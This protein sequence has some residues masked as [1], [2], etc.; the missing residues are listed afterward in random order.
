[1]RRLGDIGPGLGIHID[2]CL[3]SKFEAVG[4]RL[5]LTEQALDKSTA[6][7]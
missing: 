6:L 3:V 1:M 4:Y 7:M 5:R 2:P